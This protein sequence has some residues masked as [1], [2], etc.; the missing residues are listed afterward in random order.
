MLECGSMRSHPPSL[1][2]SRATTTCFDGIQYVLHEHAHSSCYSHW[3]RT[4]H[5][6]EAALQCRSH[7]KGGWCMTG[8]DNYK[9]SLIPPFPSSVSDASEFQQQS[10]L[11]TIYFISFLKKWRKGYVE[12]SEVILLS[13]WHNCD[14]SFANANFIMHMVTWRWRWARDPRLCLY[15]W[16]PCVCR[17]IPWVVL[18]FDGFLC[19]RSWHRT[20]RWHDFLLPY[21]LLWLTCWFL[22]SNLSDQLKESI[23]ILYVFF[24]CSLPVESQ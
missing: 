9:L 24:R 18:F 6:Q 2:S 16:P 10:Y 5:L 4:R 15:S 11:K 19:L 8:L 21:D 7:S 22:L 14:V 13:L 20:S 23:C 12:T 3:Q 1:I 17:L